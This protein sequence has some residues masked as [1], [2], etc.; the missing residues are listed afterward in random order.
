MKLA[1]RYIFVSLSVRYYFWK[2]IEVLCDPA[3][4]GTF[5]R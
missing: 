1:I 5:C 2:E 4:D 3:F